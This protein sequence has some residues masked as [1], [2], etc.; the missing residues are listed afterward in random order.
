MPKASC[1]AG[2]GQRP[3]HWYCT[4]GWTGTCP[5]CVPPPHPHICAMSSY[6][7]ESMENPWNTDHFSYKF[8]ACLHARKLFS[9]F[10][11]QLKD[12]VG[13]IVI[14]GVLLA[15]PYPWVA[16]A[17]EAAAPQGL[18]TELGLYFR[19][20]SWDFSHCCLITP[21]LN[22]I[23]MMQPVVKNNSKNKTKQNKRQQQKQASTPKICN[24]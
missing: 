14:R 11:H 18:S 16:R 4:M 21:Y 10:R 17:V 9:P 15:S 6:T 5:A 3:S 12:Q 23:S 20:R 22:S 2:A 1:A 19:S 8:C 24:V 13:K 7:A